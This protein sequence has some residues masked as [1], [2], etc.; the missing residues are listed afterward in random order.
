MDKWLKFKFENKEKKS[1][2]K[3]P[4]SERPKGLEVRIYLYGTRSHHLLALCFFC[5]ENLAN[6]LTKHRHMFFTK[7]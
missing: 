7:L 1:V 3:K 2:K 4:H 5:G 6:S